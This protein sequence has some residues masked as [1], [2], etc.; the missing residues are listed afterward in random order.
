MRHASTQLGFAT[1]HLTP[2]LRLHYAEQGDPTGEAIIFLHAYADSWYSYSRVLPLL[3][4]EY[5]A[6]VPDQ[7][8]HGDSDKPE[9]CYTADDFTADVVAFMDAVGIERAT[10]V[11]DSSSGMIVRQVALSY[12]RR[13]RRLV[14]IGAPPTLVDNEAVLEFLEEV[15]KL[16]DPV[17]AEFVREFVSGIVHHPVPEEFLETMLSESLKVPARVWRDYWEGVALTVDHRARLGEI[18][19]PALV[20]WG[21]RDALSPREEQERLAAEIP[22]AT[23]RVYPDTGHLVHWERPEWVVRDLEAFMKTHPPPNSPS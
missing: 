5:H 7:R 15:R 2:G 12:P 17:P 3:S 1:A 9:C 8:G 21:E 16:D 11:G 18:D 4:P 20:L 6:F 23:L 14:L 13:V 10:L 22:D 19:P